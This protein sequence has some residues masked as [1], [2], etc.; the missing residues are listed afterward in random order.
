M[1]EFYLQLSASTVD[2]GT[3]DFWNQDQNIF[4]T[5]NSW[6][7]ILQSRARNFHKHKFQR[8]SFRLFWKFYDGKLLKFYT[9]LY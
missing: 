6:L 4:L 2:A 1:F 9:D 8:L 7:Y 5:E 3:V